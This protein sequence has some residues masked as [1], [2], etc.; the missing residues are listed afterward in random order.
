[1]SLLGYAP[2]LGLSAAHTSGGLLG[3]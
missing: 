2:L 3:H 1:M